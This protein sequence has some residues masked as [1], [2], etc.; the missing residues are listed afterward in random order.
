L[1]TTALSI[2]FARLLSARASGSRSIATAATPRSSLLAWTTNRS[3]GRQCHSSTN[4]GPTRPLRFIPQEQLCGGPD[5]GPTRRPDLVHSGRPVLDLRDARQ[6]AEAAAHRTTA[7]FDVR[8]PSRTQAEADRWVRPAGVFVSHAE[9]L[10]SLRA[11]ARRGPVHLR[12][13][14]SRCESP[15]PPLA[16]RA[17]GRRLRWGTAALATA[18]VAT[19]PGSPRPRRTSC[20]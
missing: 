16:A 7:A 18:S 1:L 17:S 8:V 13:G 19:G 3:A 12:I 2:R 9:T 10:H 4:S 6:Q 11:R 20:R 5:R 15:S 14:A